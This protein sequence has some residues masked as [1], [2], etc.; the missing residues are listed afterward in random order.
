MFVKKEY[1]I[2][3]LYG[4]RSAERRTHNINNNF[5]RVLYIIDSMEQFKPQRVGELNPKS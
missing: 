1:N 3:K 2:K 4:G 5:Y